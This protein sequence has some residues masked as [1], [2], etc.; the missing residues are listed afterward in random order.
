M[1]LLFP[2][3]SSL[4]MYEKLKTDGL[5]NSNFELKIQ[6]YDSHFAFSRTILTHIDSALKYA[7]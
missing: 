7:Q 1:S 5:F 4:K 6:K 3:Y 2:S